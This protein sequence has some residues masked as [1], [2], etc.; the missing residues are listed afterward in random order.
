MLFYGYPTKCC[1]DVCDAFQNVRPLNFRDCIRPNSLNRPTPTSGHENVSQM[2]YNIGC[3]IF[4]PS[5]FLTYDW[6]TYLSIWCC[7][8]VYQLVENSSWTQLLL[9][10]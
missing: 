6:H 5:S 2:F 1:S 8:Y 9:C 4:P 3:W 7:R 10:Y